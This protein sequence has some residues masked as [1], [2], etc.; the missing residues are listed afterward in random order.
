MKTVLAVLVMM[1]AV[2]H[3]DSKAWSTGKAVIG[4][5]VTTVGGINAS[6][7]RSSEVYD[8][9][10][11]I[12]MAKASDLKTALDSIQ[13]E[14]KLDVLAAI[15]SIA[16]GFEG[17]KA[18]TIVVALKGT[19]HKAL[20]A[21]AQKLAKADGKQVA[22]TTD[23]KLTKYDGM[24]DKPIY[25]DWLASDVFAI[26]SAP[27]DKELT[28]A[29]L[30]SGVTSAKDLKTALAATDK[31]ASIWG[32]YKDERALPNNL[33]K[34]EQ[35]YGSAKIT[36]KKIDFTSHMITDSPK[37]AQA[38]TD[39]ANKQ[40]AAVQTGGSQALQTALKNVTVK[41]DN[42]AVA[43]TGS[44]TSDDVFPLLMSVMM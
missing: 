26:A 16:F 27:D 17:N 37:A 38:V 2:A 24:S 21:C 23:G 32:V 35:I 42:G 20:D 9:L 18:G 13:K 10:V 14:C 11:P 15:D 5:N 8:K 36:N 40:L 39:E 29:T 34:M 4:P 33:G 44:I 12:L 25:V 19:N 30:V 22:I 1:S 6:S 43:A 41:V 31:A 3:A 28:K 7:V